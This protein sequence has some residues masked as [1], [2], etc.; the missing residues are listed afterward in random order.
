M[1]YD[2]L[3][4]GGGP[5]GLSA[6]L[7]LGRHVLVCDDDRPRNATSRA[8]NAFLTRDGISPAEFRHAARADLARYDTVEYRRAQVID[9]ERIEGGFEATLE[10]GSVVR[11]RKLLIATGVVDE[12][13][14]IDGIRERW[15]H[16]VFPCPFCDAL[17]F[18]EQPIAVYGCG[19]ERGVE[20]A[21]ELLTWSPHVTLLT[22]GSAAPCEKNRTRCERLKITVDVR[23]IV[24][25]EGPSPRLEH[26]RF[27][28]GARLQCRALF[29]LTTQHQRSAFAEKLGCAPLTDE[30]TVETDDLQRTKLRGVCVAGNAAEG[31]QS[32]IIAAAEGY[33]AAYALND[34]LVEDFVAVRLKPD[35]QRSV[36]EHS[37]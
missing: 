25:L 19:G 17:E 36:S 34:E 11:A 6:A 12:L 33:K 1:Q 32:A 13:P 2:V 8:V 35:V 3:V 7:V 5:A 16:S 18:R 26:V 29:M 37:A 15:G 28:D 14:A 31:M 9:V 10:N 23:R 20:F 4:I 21:L 27:E 30:A 22:D 24:A